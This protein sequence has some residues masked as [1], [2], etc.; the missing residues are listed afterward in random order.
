MTR[1]REGRERTDLSSTRVFH[2]V[3]TQLKVFL[4]PRKFRSLLDL[5]EGLTLMG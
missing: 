2:A 4:A 1:W 3:L 5:F